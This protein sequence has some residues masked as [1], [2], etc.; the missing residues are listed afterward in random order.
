MFMHQLRNDTKVTLCEEEKRVFHQFPKYHMEVERVFDQ[1][2]KVPHGSGA[3][4][5]SVPK[6]TIWKLSVYSISS[7]KCHMEVEQ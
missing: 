2:T 4:I 7:Q 1:F 5:R 3:C 6:S